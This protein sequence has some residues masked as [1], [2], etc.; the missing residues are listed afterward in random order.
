MRFKPKFNNIFSDIVYAI[1]DAL[2]WIFIIYVGVYLGV[3][4]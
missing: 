2:Y 4:S 3:H 1:F